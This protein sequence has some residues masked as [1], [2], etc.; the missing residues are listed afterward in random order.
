MLEVAQ[1][2][3]QVSEE[4]NLDNA[5]RKRKVLD[6]SLEAAWPSHSP[7]LLHNFVNHVAGFGRAVFLIVYKHP[8]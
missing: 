6:L 7:G 8:I 2:P 5:G 4:K 3:A 1:T